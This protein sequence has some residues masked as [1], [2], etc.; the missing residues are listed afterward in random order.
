MTKTSIQQEKDRF[1]VQHCWSAR[2]T[3]CCMEAKALA[4]RAA[5]EDNISTD[6][7]FLNISTCFPEE[8]FLLLFSPCLTSC[9]EM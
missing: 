1:D 4:P 9:N 8:G 2:K 5:I 3:W 7:L 6:L